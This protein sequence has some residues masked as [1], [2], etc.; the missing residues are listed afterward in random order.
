MRA[1]RASFGCRWILSVV[2]VMGVLLGAIAPALATGVFD[3]PPLQ[4]GANSWVIDRAEAISRI[5]ENQL[6]SDFQELAA[7]TGNEVRLVTIRRLD[8]DTTIDSFADELFAT[9]YPTP[10]AQ[11]N[12]T[13]LVLDTL[14]NNVAIRR[15]EAA[16]SLLTDAIADSVVAESVA[17]PLREGGK[18]NE[19]FLLV[20]DRLV[21]VLSGQPDP[22]PPA[23]KVTLSVE[24]T[25]AEAEEADTKSSAL[26]VIGL[27]AIATIVPMATY[28]LYVGFS[29]N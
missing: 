24:S 29:S 17:I 6:N 18:Y 10:E 9:W 19:A 3:L 22:G 14:T 20:K 13:L 23:E 15:G 16:S 26:W 11:A 28:F 4:A 8:Y 1:G 25:F 21:A 27:L 2:L 5:N 12:Q 7:A